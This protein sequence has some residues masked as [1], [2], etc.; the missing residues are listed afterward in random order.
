MTPAH[1]LDFWF[2]GCDDNKALE[3][4]QV[5]KWVNTDGY[6]ADFVTRHFI[7]AVFD[8]QEGH[9]DSW[10]QT[11]EGALALIILFDVFTR[12]VYAG[13]HV[14]FSN[15]YRAVETLKFALEKGFDKKW[16]LIQRMFGYLPFEHAEDHHL[17]ETS[18]KLYAVLLKSAPAV[19]QK[20]FE[21][22]LS[23]AIAHRDVIEKFGRFPQRN[24]MVGRQS[25]PKELSFIAGLRRLRSRTPVN[26]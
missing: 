10:R 25:T 3:V 5:N 12:Y 1:I 6:T 13:T 14:A 15:D 26:V 20:W 4:K 23:T 19:N 17:Q 2:S 9:Y 16:T 21:S 8:A 24:A 7:S 18:V 11:P 22:A